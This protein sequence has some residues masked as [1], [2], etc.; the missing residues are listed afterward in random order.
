[1]ETQ[2]VVAGRN[3]GTVTHGCSVGEDRWPNKAMLTLG[4]GLNQ[5]GLVET[6]LTLHNSFICMV[7][8]VLVNIEGLERVEGSCVV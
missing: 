4:H 5:I 8:Y 7:I 2:I 1:V 6:A 3:T